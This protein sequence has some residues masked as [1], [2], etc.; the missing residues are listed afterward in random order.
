MEFE[1]N[2]KIFDKF[3]ELNSER[4]VFRQITYNDSE[5]LFNLRTNNEVMKYMDTHTME[6]S[7]ESKIFIDSINESFKSGLGINWGI[8]E[9][10]SNTFIG[11]FG[12]WRI[13]IKN[14]RGEIGFALHPDSWGKGYMQETIQTMIR[15]GFDKIKLHSIEANVNPENSDCIKLLERNSFKKEAYFR[16]NF[17]FNNKFKDSLIYSLLEKDFL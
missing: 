17:L 6:S 2:K 11:Y 12:F 5:T 14:C 13:D 1:I 10:S 16:E 4:L 3:P 9:K 15:F 7:S 8:I